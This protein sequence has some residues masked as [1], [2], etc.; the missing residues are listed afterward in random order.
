MVGVLIDIAMEETRNDDVLKWYESSRRRRGRWGNRNAQVAEA[1]QRT[2]PDAAL[3]IWGREVEALSP[4]VKPVAYQQ[5]APYLKKKRKV[6]K[7]LGR[8]QEW[9]DTIQRLRGSRQT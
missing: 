3:T 2:R 6:Y 4:P 7:R 8:F 1:V 9:L 5:A